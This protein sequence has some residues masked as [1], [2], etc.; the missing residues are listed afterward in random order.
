MKDL[1]DKLKVKYWNCPNVPTD[2][3]WPE[4]ADSELSYDYLTPKRQDIGI[5]IS[6][7]GTVSV[8]LA[9]GYF[10]ALH[11]LDLLKNVGYVSGVSGG[12]WVSTP[13]AY[14][15][16][17][18]KRIF[19]SC[20]LPP[21][22]LTPANVGNIVP[23]DGKGTL[24]SASDIVSHAAIE[25][26][27]IANLFAQHDSFTDAVGKIFLEPLGIKNEEKYF[28]SDEKARDQ[29][30][31]RQKTI[32]NQGHPLTEA[33]FV[34]LGEGDGSGSQSGDE[35]WDYRPYPIMNTTF[36][37]PIS[38]DDSTKDSDYDVASEHLI[39]FTPI[40]AGMPAGQ[41][42]PASSD[43]NYFGGYYE[44][45]GFDSDTEIT[46][47]G[48]T[49]EMEVETRKR[50][51][52]RKKVPFSLCDPVGT[53]GAAPASVSLH[54][55][56]LPPGTGLGPFLNLFKEVSIPW[57][58]YWNDYPTQPRIGQHRFYFGDGGII[59]NTGIVPLLRRQLSKIVVFISQPFKLLTDDVVVQGIKQNNLK[60]SVQK[61]Y[62]DAAQIYGY[63]DRIFGYNEAARLFGQPVYQDV[64]KDPNWAIWELVPIK[65]SPG[66]SHQVF[67]ASQWANFEAAVNAASGVGP[68]VV[69]DSFT[70]VENTLSGVPGYGPVDITWMFIDTDP[71]FNKTVTDNGVDLPC[72]FPLI[73]TFGQNK[74]HMIQLTPE[75]ANL[76]GSQ[77]YHSIKT[78]ESDTTKK[79]FSKVLG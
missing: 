62:D 43:Q 68:V 73:K 23:E 71:A 47:T 78:I 13:W 17:T 58:F 51:V 29:I 54:I 46:P 6:G 55:G 34:L 72:D 10:A 40:Y 25:R 57:F 2:F 19:S 12:C 48:S 35:D 11:S 52:I 50:G 15:T 39:E 20:V 33:D 38:P 45:F 5:C 56:N 3:Q 66:P 27:A 44:T 49:G 16:A 31:A 63:G 14:S 28:A 8:S 9:A 22:A 75:Q 60:Y 30:L 7:G 24:R 18:Q 37:Q 59:E 70:V 76:L 4:Q 32:Q 67:D 26:Y 69:N 74:G 21:E 64:S 79:Y 42:N 36:F 65:E 1:P 77:A 53:S 61:G 41:P